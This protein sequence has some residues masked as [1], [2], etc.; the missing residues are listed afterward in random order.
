MS[1]CVKKLQGG[2]LSELLEEE[3]RLTPL[4]TERALA[5]SPAEKI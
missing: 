4:S 2:K 3:K 1:D 5:N